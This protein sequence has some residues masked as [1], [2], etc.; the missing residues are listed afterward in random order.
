MNSGARSQ[1]Y[2]V[3]GA[4]ANAAQSLGL[5]PQGEETGQVPHYPIKY[6][7]HRNTC[8]C[9]IYTVHIIHIVHSTCTGFTCA[10]TH[11]SIACVLFTSL[12]VKVTLPSTPN[13]TVGINQSEVAIGNRVDIF[14]LLQVCCIELCSVDM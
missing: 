1:C 7:Y 8:S 10:H 13:V 5:S 12:A 2:A 6:V 4:T 11:S 14:V 9:Y 3:G